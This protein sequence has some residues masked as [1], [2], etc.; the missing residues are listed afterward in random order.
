MGWDKPKVGTVTESVML[1][2][3]KA[4]DQYTVFSTV[5]GILQK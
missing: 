3:I 2:V 1:R 4:D 5:N